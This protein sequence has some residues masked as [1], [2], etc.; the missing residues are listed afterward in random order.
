MRDHGRDVPEDDMREIQPDVFGWQGCCGRNLGRSRLVAWDDDVF[1]I[2]I[3]VVVELKLSE[4]GISGL[5]REV[6]R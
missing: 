1:V 4:S 2:I 3:F 5:L 6:Q